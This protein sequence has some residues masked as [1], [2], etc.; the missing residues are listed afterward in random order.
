MEA[1]MRFDSLKELKG[2]AFRRLTGVQRSTLEAMTAL[3]SSGLVPGIPSAASHFYKVEIA[4]SIRL[5]GLDT[6]EQICDRRRNGT[7][8]PVRHYVHDRCQRR[9]G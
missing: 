2:E 5:G 6:W 8:D 9:C 1:T 7:G 4:R 3:C